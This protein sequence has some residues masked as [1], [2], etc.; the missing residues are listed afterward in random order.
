MRRLI[1]ATQRL[2]SRDPILAATVA[3]VRAL[4]ER[5]DELVVICDSA[6]PGVE[7]ANARVHE[8]RSAT[9]FQRGARFAAALVRELRPRP[10]GVV[11]HM[12]P[13]YVVVAAPI[14]RPLRVP[15]LLWYTHWKA[16]P[17]V[18][19][20]ER[21]AT[22]VISVD[23]RSFPFATPKLRAVGHGIDL[24]EFECSDARTGDGPLRA[25]ALGRYS[26]TKGLETIVRG[27]AL[28]GNAELRVHGASGGPGDDEH[29]RHL[30]SLARSLGLEAVIA[31]PVPRA[32]VPRLLAESDVLVNNTPAGSA[33]KVV[34]EAAASCLPAAVSNPV[35]DDLVP[36][37]LRFRADDP[38]SLA[39][40]L[41]SFD[42][43]RR[44]ELR[45]QVLA[46][47]SVEHWADAVLATLARS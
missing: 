43:R 13:L 6:E 22:G 36:P 18:R 24:S 9:Q 26:S 27:V 39:D 40:V 41:R 2:D 23:R 15:L 45:E 25:L 16:H 37:D 11:A 47:H 8:F 3:K 28:A 44:P 20:A 38:A 1:F 12:I 5:V 29:K 32:E 21:L 46:R 4:A 34:F 10:L 14:V 17:L 33:D 42:R 7:P 31:G 35:F 19:V 30:E